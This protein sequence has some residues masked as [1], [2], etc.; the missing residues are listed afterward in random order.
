VAAVPALGLLDL[1]PELLDLLILL[2]VALV[3]LAAVLDAIPEAD[4]RGE[5][6]DE[7]RAERRNDECFLP[8]DPKSVSEWV[9]WTAR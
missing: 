2:D 3:L 9:P 5:G 4:G 6:A 7:G 8:S 1:G